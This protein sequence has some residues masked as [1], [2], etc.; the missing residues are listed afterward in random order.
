MQSRARIV[1]S[2]MV[3]G[4]FFRAFVRDA[5]LSLGVTGWVRNRPDGK[6]EAVLEGE[7]HKVME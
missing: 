5:A 1:I 6:V 3:Q 7:R 4:V 2:G